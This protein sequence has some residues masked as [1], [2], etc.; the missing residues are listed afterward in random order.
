MDA[1]ASLDQRVQWLVD[2]AEIAE[3]L[4]GYALCIDRRDWEGLRA[5]YAENGVM[6][7][8]EVSVPRDSVAELSEKILAGCSASHHQ[9]GDPSIV[10]D[11]DRARTRSHYFATHV[12]AGGS[13]KRQ[14]GGW[15]DC[16]LQRTDSG[17][18]FTTVRSTTIWRSGEPL[19]LH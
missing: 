13:V 3:C 6:Q 8:G 14:A 9:V 19:Q 4:I 2:R 17:W 16:E 7:H 18:K 1:A 12:A 15:Y 5:S 10:V 11:G